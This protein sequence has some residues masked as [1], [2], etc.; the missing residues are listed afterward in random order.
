MSFSILESIVTFSLISISKFTCH[1]PF[2]QDIRCG[3]SILAF[4]NVQRTLVKCLS[5]Q[6]VVTKNE[7]RDGELRHDI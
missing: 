1:F 2:D 5:P 3:L 6:N 7:V 4:E